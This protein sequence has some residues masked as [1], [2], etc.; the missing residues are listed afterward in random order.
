LSI[1]EA[2]ATWFD[3]SGSDRPATESTHIQTAWDRLVA[4]QCEISNSSQASTDVDKARLLAAS[5]PHSADWLSAPPIASVSVHLSDEEVR[6][7]VAHRLGCKACEPHN[8]GCG[9]PVDARGL[10]SD[11]SQ[12]LH[13]DKD[14]RRTDSCPTN[15]RC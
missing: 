1:P 13:S 5:T 2:E 11:S 6:I 10:L 9:K 14:H 8:C 15:P 4:R 3:L 7:A 12:I